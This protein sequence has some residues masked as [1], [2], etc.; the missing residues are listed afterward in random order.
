ML[1]KYL[2]PKNDYAFKKIF[3]TE[4]H[5]GIP[6][7]FLNAVLNLEGEESIID[8]TFLDLKQPAEIAFRKESVVD[9]LVQDQKGRKFIVEM[10]VAKIKGFEKR[11]QYYAAKTYCANFKMGDQYIDLKRIVFLAITDYIVFPGKSYYKSNHVTLDDKSYEHDLKDF[12]YTFIELPKFKKTLEELT[13]LEEKWYYF[14]KHADETKNIKEIFTQHPQIQ[15]AYE[16]LN[17]YH[18][19]EEELQYYEKSAMIAA[20]AKGVLAAQEEE[21]MEKGWKKG[22]KE[23]IQEGLQKGLQKGLQEGHQK[24]LQEG[25]QKLQAEKL[26]I[27]YKMLK[28]KRPLEEILEDTG[29]TEEEISQLNP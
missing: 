17:S 20:D 14:L 28:R 2:D 3:G 1:S 13:T 21:L 9:V 29:F 12:S 23:G 25:L 22:L 18:W 5:K 19:S 24:G 11:A 8:L 10:Q 26:A 4:K 16:V 6:I 15:E 7:N 27:A